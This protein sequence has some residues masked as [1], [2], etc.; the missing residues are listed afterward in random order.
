MPWLPVTATL[1]RVGT[2]LLIILLAA[3]AAPRC[4]PGGG[5]EMQVY[6]LY[7]GRSVA[8]RGEVTDREWQEFRDQIIT[9]ALPNGYTVVDAKGAWMNPRL[10]T[11]ISEN[12]KVLIVALPDG[13]D[14]LSAINHIRD[15]WR[16]RFHQYV[17]GMTVQTGRGS[18]SPAEVSP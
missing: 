18:F 12:T 8:G 3:C 14:G 10:R 5:Q 1:S 17:V 15:V 9:P 7:F 4:Q 11:T 16:Q 13:P 6:N 2:L